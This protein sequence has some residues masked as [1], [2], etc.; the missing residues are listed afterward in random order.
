ME[1]GTIEISRS[2]LRFNKFRRYSVIIDDNKVA[3]IKNNETISLDV[4]PGLHYFY[5]RMDLFKS[6]KITFNIDS[7]QT[8]NFLISDSR[9]P[10]WQYIAFV[11][12][13]WFCVLLTVLVNVALIIAMAPI[14]GAM[15]GFT[16][17]KPNIQQISNTN[18]ET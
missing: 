16:L 5:T 13:V 17:G 4:D 3:S 11:F 14:I 1:K 9:I 18:R 15:Y 10:S 7:K 8:F 6:N 2:N 12:F